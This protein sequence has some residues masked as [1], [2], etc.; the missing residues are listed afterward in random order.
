M[1]IQQSNKLSL[2]SFL[3]FSYMTN[4]QT[5]N[6][7]YLWQLKV[8]QQASKSVRKASKLP[9][10]VSG[11]LFLG[12]LYISSYDSWRLASFMML[13]SA[14]TLCFYTL[15]LQQGERRARTQV[16]NLYL[17]STFFCWGCINVFLFVICVWFWSACSDFFL[18]QACMQTVD[19]FLEWK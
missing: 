13:I 5:Y 15:D 19:D 18:F 6:F 3:V 11:M 2:S 16:G 10:G 4:G 14:Y 12:H 7:W 17:I 1:A 9:Q 8:K